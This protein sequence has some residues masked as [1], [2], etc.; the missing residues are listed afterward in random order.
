MDVDMLLCALVA[1]VFFG[2]IGLLT[3][4]QIDCNSVCAPLESHF[5]AHD[6]ECMCINEQHQLVVP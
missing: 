6:L 4:L 3:Y 1:G 2:M 5:N